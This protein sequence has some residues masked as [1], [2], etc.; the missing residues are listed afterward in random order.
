MKNILIFG[1]NGFIGSNIKKY[2]QNQFNLDTISRKNATFCCDFSEKKISIKKKYD[3][4]IH[5]A[6]IAHGNLNLS[7]FDSCINL[8]TNFLDSFLIIPKKIIFISSVS[9]YGLKKGLL[10]N[11]LQKLNPSDLNGKAKAISEKI[12]K[13]WSIK[14]SVR[15]TILRLPLVVG[16]NA[17][18]NFFK[19]INAIKNKY[20]FTINGGIAKKSMVLVDCIS[21]NIINLSK[22]EGIYNL[23][24]GDHP[25]FKVLINKISNSF[26]SNY[27]PINLNIFFIKTFLLF[28][29][30]KIKLSFEKL[31][32]SLTFDDSKAR[33]LL[34]WKSKKVIKEI[35]HIL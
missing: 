15:Y 14:N 13:E 16:K 28:L 21:S 26:D 10:V 9:V 29:P 24:D 25:S 34:N 1:S 32:Y 17:P 23:T 8:T 30:K 6:G 3:L 11:E 2:L 35:K 27:V 20:F 12:I 18:G 7:N 33:K 4:V 5:C 31:T 22:K 19:M